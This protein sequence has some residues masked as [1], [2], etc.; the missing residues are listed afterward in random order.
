MVPVYARMP[1]KR[2]QPILE[3]RTWYHPIV[4]QLSSSDSG[5]NRSPT[6]AGGCAQPATHLAICHLSSQKKTGGFFGPFPNMFNV[7]T[8]YNLGF[9]DAGGQ[10]LAPLEK[11]LIPLLLHSYTNWYRIWSTDN[12]SHCMISK[13]ST[14]TVRPMT[15]CNFSSP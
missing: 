15:G 2:N 3:F 5:W 8:W 9:F 4:A 14:N 13:F 10:N 11:W 6:S 1:L 12:R 7:G